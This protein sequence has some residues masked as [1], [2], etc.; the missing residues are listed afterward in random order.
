MYWW[1]KICSLVVISGLIYTIYLAFWGIKTYFDIQETRLELVS[2]G[3]YTSNYYSFGDLIMLLLSLG[4]V[5]VFGLL[6][7]SP[8]LYY[9]WVKNPNN[10]H[11]NI[12]AKIISVFWSVFLIWGLIL[13]ISSDTI[14]FIDLIGF[15][16]LIAF[17]VP[18][19]YFA[20]KK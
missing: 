16:G 2:L 14:K 10:K 20:W 5:I 6:F 18:I 12:L 17:I 4:F 19:Y 9:G 15:L 13:F 11:V 7:Y 1:A 3:S 8:F